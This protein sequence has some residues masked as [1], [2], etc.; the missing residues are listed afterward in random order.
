MTAPMT[1]WFP[2]CRVGLGF[3]AALVCWGPVAMAGGTVAPIAH[4]REVLADRIGPEAAGARPVRIWPG[5]VITDSAVPAYARRVA[6]AARY[7]GFDVPG[8]HLLIE[9][10]VIEGAL[11]LGTSLPVVLRHVLV[12]AREPRPWHVLV[13]P[14]SGPVH[15]LWSDIG[16]AM[17][18]RS[19]SPHVG[20]AL[21]LRGDGARVFRSRVGAAADGVQI[22]GRDIRIVEC[23]IDGL[24]TMPGDHNDAIQLFAP[25]RDVAIE[26]S[27]IDNAHAQTSAIAVLGQ[28]V[29]IADN[30]L[31]G[32]GWTLYGGAAKPGSQDAAATGVR[33]T[34]NVFSRSRFAKVGSFG[35]VTYWAAPPGSGNVWRDNRD[36]RGV[37]IAP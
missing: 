29:S 25:A 24:L 23:R 3:V 18:R 27:L 31:A 5:A 9:N 17:R 20:V 19:A 33:V 7:D 30:W 11:D 21:A 36:E 34:G 10:G 13:R 26:R 22:G 35:P 6:D 15:V 32:G 8:P 1:R 4:G 16:G 14:G 37:E 12:E 28:N 2:S